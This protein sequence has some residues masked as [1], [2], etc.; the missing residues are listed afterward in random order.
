MSVETKDI[1]IREIAASDHAAVAAM[2][3]KL[4]H[5]VGAE[6][7][8]TAK[9]LA[10]YGPLGHRCTEILVAEAQGAI[11]GIALYSIVFSAWRGQPGIYVSDLFVEDKARGLGIGTRL[12]RAAVAREMPRGCAYL[13][14]DV[15]KDNAEG[16]SFYEKR[17]FKSSDRER[18]MVLEKDGMTR[19]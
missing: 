9:D 15:D 1:I 18:T 10:A 12:L 4:G 11:I 17:G 8:V 3:R 19:L 2:L 6:P 5:H 7:K 13:K 16:L 14:L